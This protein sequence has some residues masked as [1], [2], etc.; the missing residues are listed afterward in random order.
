M[1]KNRSFWIYILLTFFILA[2]A[3]Y[4]HAFVYLYLISPLAKLFW[5][6]YRLFASIHQRVYWFLLVGLIVFLAYRIVFFVSKEPVDKDTEGLDK[7]KRREQ[8]W[9]KTISNAI[10]NEDDSREFLR[11][12][13]GQLFLSASNLRAQF[14]MDEAET[15]LLNVQPPL[16]TK[17]LF[18]LNQSEGEPVRT[19]G[20][21]FTFA[22]RVFQSLGWRK[23]RMRK[24]IYND[25]AEILQSMEDY[26]E[27]DH[28]KESSR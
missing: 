22:R 5:V 9:V 19:K 27:I 23:A 18:L 25:I 6:V 4:F 28:E 12:Q 20:V 14:R 16:P 26:L 21:D 8:F 3:V 1:L 17:L 2:S 24:V 7:P 15:I 10:N 13:L 11:R